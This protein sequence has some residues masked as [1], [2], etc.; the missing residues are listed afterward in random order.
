MVPDEH[1]SAREIS[2]ML[3]EETRAA[4]MADHFEAFAECIHLPHFIAS[5][6]D[7]RVLETLQDLRDIFKKVIQDYVSKRITELVRFC[8]VAE[9]RSPTRIEA[10]HT[11]HL[12]S[13]N[14][15]I[16]DPFPV[17]SVLEFIDGRWKISSSQYAVE[18]TTAVGFALDTQ[19]QK[20]LEK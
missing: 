7:K 12:M 3:L 19:R 10:T 13:G 15:R 20:S 16:G 4:L 5:S 6:D 1:M 17:F 18:K 2:E 8:D 9:Y 11:T 14:Q